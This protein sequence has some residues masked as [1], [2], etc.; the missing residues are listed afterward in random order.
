MSSAKDLLDA[1]V[2]TS[3]IL[4]IDGDLRTIDVPL[5]F[6][7]FGV[8]SD[9][10]VLRVRFRGP[11]YYRG[12]DLSTFQI[13]VNVK[14]ANDEDDAYMVTD[15]VVDD[16]TNVI[17]FSWLIGRFVAQYE[18]VIEFSL[19]FRDIDSDGVVVREFNTTTATG[20][21]LRGLEASP[22]VIQENPDI[23]EW[24]LARLE[25]LENS[26]GGSIELD[27]TLTIRGKAADAKAVG[28][29]I[30]NINLILDA[31]NGEVV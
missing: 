12:V 16:E 3:R 17:N 14:N 27:E 6:G 24:I 26:S 23:L 22:K 18:G 31:I 13:R 19:C 29:A 21:I 25:I 8:E 7:V 4:T 1:E 11:R 10:D 30:G 15:A 5:D 9:D 20:R 28:D 2:G